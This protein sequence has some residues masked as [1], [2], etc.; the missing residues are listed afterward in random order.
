MEPPVKLRPEKLEGELPLE[1]R[2]IDDADL[3]RVLVDVRGLA[4]QQ[5]RVPTVE[6]LH[7]SPPHE[8]RRRQCDTTISGRRQ[9]RLRKPIRLYAPNITRPPSTAINCPVMK[10]DPSPHKKTSV[11]P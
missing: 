11:G 9:R 5:H 6:P 10:R 3:Q 4:V 8:R 7:P 1:A 2:H